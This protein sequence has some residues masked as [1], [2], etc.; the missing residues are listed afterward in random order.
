MAHAL[1]GLPTL[2]NTRFQEPDWAIVRI[3][4]QVSGYPGGIRFLF[5][6]VSFT[7][8]ERRKIVDQKDLSQHNVY[9][10]VSPQVC[11]YNLS[12]YHVDEM[13]T[14]QSTFEVFHGKTAW[15]LY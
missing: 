8:L 5:V 1:E 12:Q 2:Q 9:S 4:W 15:L 13:V 3:F 7:A 6:R 14:W 10:Q 11:R